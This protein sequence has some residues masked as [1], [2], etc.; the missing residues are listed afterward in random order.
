MSGADSMLSVEGL[1]AGYRS[2]EGEVPVLENFSLRIPC[3][4]VMAVLGPS[5]CGKSTLIHVLAGTHPPDGGTVVFAAG[6]VRRALSPKTHKIAVI[7]QNGGLLPW[8]TVRQN[9]LLPGKLRHEPA[10][11]EEL[12][13]IAR[14]LEVDGLLH[15]YPGELSGGQAQ[16]AALARAFLQEPDLLLMDEPFSALD[17]ITRGGAWDLFLKIWK[18]K[19]PAALMV[20]HSIEEALYL[21]NTLVVLGMR[22]G[23]IVFQASNPYFGVLG[24]SSPEYSALKQRLRSDLKPE[25]GEAGAK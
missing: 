11:E 19:R 7:P 9:C 2:R 21:G 4:E 5:G 25:R 16:R 24:P 12:V 13:S 23:E 1:T 17:A 22:R 18:R 15:R 10:K 20:T 3:G 6:G 8:K 14:A